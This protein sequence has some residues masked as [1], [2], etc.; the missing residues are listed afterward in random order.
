MVS[1]S[2]G[3][4]EERARQ[5]DDLE[6]KQFVL[7]GVTIVALKGLRGEFAEAPVD[8]ECL[9][10]ILI[11]AFEERVRLKSA[12][13]GGVT[14]AHLFD[15]NDFS[16]FEFVVNQRQALELIARTSNLALR[17]FFDVFGRAAFQ[18]LSA[19][20]DYKIDF[21]LGFFLS[22]VAEYFGKKELLLSIF[23]GEDIRWWDDYP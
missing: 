20:V 13:C 23:N 15:Y 4:V 3:S 1:V 10:D 22:V 12:L 6:L 17:E 5:I 19:R 11:Q 9:F 7:C 14:T 16:K 18:T 21:D 8:G 2:W